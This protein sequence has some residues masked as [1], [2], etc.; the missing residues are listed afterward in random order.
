MHLTFITD[1]VEQFLPGQILAAAYGACDA[2]VL[3]RYI[4]PDPA[5]A[6]KAQAQCATLNL[7]MAFAQCGQAKRAVA[8]GVFMIAHPHQG[9]VEQAHYRGYNGIPMDVSTH[10]SC[11][12]AFDLGSN[13]GQRSTKFRQAV[14]LGFAFGKSPISMVA[15][16]FAA[17]HITPRGLNMALRVCANPHCG[18]GWRNRQLLDS[19]NLFDV[20]QLLAVGLSINKTLTALCAGKARHLIAHVTQA[21]GHVDGFRGSGKLHRHQGT[22]M[23]APAQEA[24]PHC[25]CCNRVIVGWGCGGTQTRLWGA[26]FNA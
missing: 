10:M 6:A 17:P 2:R 21:L 1:I 12:V 13:N 14:K 11:E 8:S 15:V 23:D 25:A 26:M 4:L 9:G 18:I 24:P 5:F 3:K 19:C 20:S 7:D 22:A 16:L